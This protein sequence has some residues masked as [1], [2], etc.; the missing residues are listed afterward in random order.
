[1][2][3]V[4]DFR[5]NNG[6]EVNVNANVASTATALDYIANTTG[7]SVSPSV[8]FDFSKTNTLDSR[9]TFQRASGATYRAANGMIAYAANNIPRFN[10]NA[11]GVCQGLLIEQSR[12]NDHWY[13][14]NIGNTNYYTFQEHIPGGMGMVLNAAAAPDGSNTATHLY[15]ATTQGTYKSVFS[16]ISI[17]SNRVYTHSVWAKSNNQPVFGVSQYDGGDNMNTISIVYTIASN[18]FIVSTNG[19]ANCAVIGGPA[20]EMYRDGWY[21]LSYTYIYTAGPAN[22][23]LQVK[24]N[25]DTTTPTVG[26]GVFYWGAQHE[27]NDKPTT[28][29]PTT[30]TSATR[31]NDLAYVDGLIVNNLSWFNPSEGT[32]SVEWNVPLTATTSNNAL[33]SLYSGY[34]GPICFW[35]ANDSTNVSSHIFYADASA[36]KGAG[37]ERFAN[38]VNLFYGNLVGSVANG[39]FYKTTYSYANTDF[40]WSVNGSYANA[41]PYTTAIPVTTRMEI[42]RSRA[43]WLDGHVKRFEYWPRKLANTDISNSTL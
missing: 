36:G 10:Y 5:V 30:T 24:Y 1:M 6:L 23:T 18:T 29:I 11:N 38:N 20:I 35:A 7:V 37:L 31:A 34:P 19:S 12:T 39:T 25:L 16:S 3:T 27:W 22:R 28:F 8:V 2:A 42:G 43:N 4:R 15:H 17:V 40:A 26:S 9:I 32:V 14:T 13:S 21:R 41:A 33:A